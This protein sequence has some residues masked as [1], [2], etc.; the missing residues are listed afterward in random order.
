M[1]K[2]I[3]LAVRLIAVLI[4]GNSNTIVTVAIQINF[5]YTITIF[6]KTVKKGLDK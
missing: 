4:V 6:T 2:P 3:V 5:Y 1:A